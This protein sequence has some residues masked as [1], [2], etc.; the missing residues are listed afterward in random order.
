MG[1]GN[2]GS[3]SKTTAMTAVRVSD[4]CVRACVLCVRTCASPSCRFVNENEC[5]HRHHHQHHQ[6]QHQPQRRQRSCAGARETKQRTPWITKAP[7]LSTATPNSP[8]FCCS[9]AVKSSL[10]STPL[11]SVTCVY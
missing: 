5:R 9:I 10:R 8:T 2:G 1:G 6:P 3:G 11:L 7:Q 4:V